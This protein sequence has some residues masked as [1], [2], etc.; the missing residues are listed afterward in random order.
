MMYIS[1][2]HIE[3]STLCQAHCSHCPRLLYHNRLPG[4]RNIGAS[5]WDQ[6]IRP[7]LSR[8]STAVLCGN[9]GDPMMNPDILH[10]VDSLLEHMKPYS[11]SISTNA[12]CGS[13]ETY[14]ALARRGIIIKYSLEGLDTQSHSRYRVGVNFDLVRDNILAGCAGAQQS[15]A[16]AW[17]EI[18]AFYVIPWSHTVAQLPDIVEF[19]R[20]VNSTILIAR[21]R[22]HEHGMSPNWHHSGRWQGAV[23][24]NENTQNFPF[25]SH[26]GRYGDVSRYTGPAGGEPDWGSFEQLLQY[27]W[28]PP[29]NWQAQTIRTR[30]DY[31]EDQT[32]D[33]EPVRA[34]EPQGLTESEFFSE[35]DQVVQ[36]NCSAYRQNNV[37]LDAD[38]QLYPCCH[39]GT[40]LSRER[41]GWV[42]TH[43]HSRTHKL[44]ERYHQV[45]FDVFDTRTRPVTEILAD[46]V[47][48]DFAL[49]HT[50]PQRRVPEYCERLCGLCTPDV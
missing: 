19:A 37:F 41:L 10:I 24:I 21:P 3:P 7:H 28:G 48:C 23:E 8:F 1:G 15:S 27:D 31:L 29:V 12:G 22:T 13:P 32:P 33:P 20:Q 50:G 49:D 44:I 9:H 36:L 17:Q 25:Q 38:L 2:I 39:Q 6:Y 16:P 11:I 26:N 4:V 34:Y 47:W 18:L 45:G 35:Y 46:P 40:H 14:E 5:E 42:T 43:H 30:P